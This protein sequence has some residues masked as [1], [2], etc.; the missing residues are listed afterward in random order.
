MEEEEA[1]VGFESQWKRV[2]DAKLPTRDAGGRNGL[3]FSGG[4]RINDGS[5]TLAKCMFEI[6]CLSFMRLAWQLVHRPS[7]VWPCSNG[8]RPVLAP[9]SH[10]DAAKTFPS[11]G[12]LIPAF[13]ES[14]CRL[15]MKGNGDPCSKQTSGRKVV[16]RYRILRNSS[17]LTIFVVPHLR[18]IGHM[19]MI[20]LSGGR[21]PLVV[22]DHLTE[23]HF[24]DT[25][26]LSWSQKEKKPAQPFEDQIDL[27]V[28]TAA[29][30]PKTRIHPID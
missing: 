27:H 29:G 25:Y 6:N 4:W 1:V 5:E 20:E 18:Q 3:S 7:H 14:H 23:I 9:V 22:L 19:E 26:R 28:L 12:G 13:Q 30:A 16:T 24:S 21:T 10:D 15:P 17:L 8:V 11:Y 2:H